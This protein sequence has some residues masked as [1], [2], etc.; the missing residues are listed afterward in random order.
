[1]TVSAA[2]LMNELS[3]QPDLGIEHVADLRSSLATQ[4]ENAEPVVLTGD[5]VA[6]VHTAGLQLLHAFVRDRAL[7]GRITT[8]TL[9]SAALIDA[10]NVLALAE[11]LGL[12]SQ[13][14]GFDGPENNG[15]SV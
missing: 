4:F 2:I 7:A 12:A 13:P 6:R 11:G 8:I 5:R 10:A 9:P 14:A 1:L 15:D 3:L